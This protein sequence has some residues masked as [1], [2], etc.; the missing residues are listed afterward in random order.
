MNA[1]LTSNRCHC[2]VCIGD[3]YGHGPCTLPSNQKLSVL[4]AA[5]ALLAD[6][7][8]RYPGEALR[9]PF[10]IALDDACNAHETPDGLLHDSCHK[11]L[12]PVRPGRAVKA[13]GVDSTELGCPCHGLERE[14]DTCRDVCK[15]LQKAT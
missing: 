6:V 1:T 10:M 2:R 9:C 12:G 3:R 4:E 13:T 11:D 5:K 7:R 14:G 15:P 8:R